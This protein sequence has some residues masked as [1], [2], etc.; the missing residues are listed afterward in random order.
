M[1]TLAIANHKGGTG[2]TTLA[3]RRTLGGASKSSFGTGVAV[4]CA[5]SLLIVLIIGAGMSPEG[6]K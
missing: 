2:K 1:K 4:G 5:V 3:E 6:Q